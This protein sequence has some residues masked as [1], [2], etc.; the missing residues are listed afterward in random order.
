MTPTLR[1]EAVELRLNGFTLGPL[2]LDLEPGKVVGLVGPN[3]SGKTTTMRVIMGILDRD[4]GL[5]EVCDQSATPRSGSW[6]EQIGYVSDK[7]IFYD[8]MSG[9]DFLDLLSRFYP[10]WDSRHATEL[11]ARFELELDARIR[12]LSLGNRVKLSLVAALAHHPRL[13][14]FD[15]PTSGLDPVVRSEVFAAL[16]DM[17]E[18]GAMTVFYS[19]H[20]L[21]DLHRMADE[22][23]FLRDGRVQTYAAKDDLIDH[24]R[25][26]QFQLDGN[27]PEVEGMVA[28]EEQGNLHEIICSDGATAAHSLAEAGAAGMRSTPMSLEEIAVQIMKEGRHGRNDDTA[29][30]RHG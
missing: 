4:Q 28:H 13:A 23:V 7:P 8:W 30:L 16:S 6:K 5:I 22:L 10:S 29:A 24:W 9:R 14:L 15:E 25:R 19:T 27:L 2:D 18:D 17:L 12:H 1:M 26:I 20:I 11:A 21:D 3:G